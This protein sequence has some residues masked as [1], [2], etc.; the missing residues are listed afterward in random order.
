MAALF[1]VSMAAILILDFM[2]Y[3]MGPDGE[4]PEAIARW[5]KKRKRIDAIRKQQAEINGL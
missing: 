3:G 1:V 5:K 2:G 4:S